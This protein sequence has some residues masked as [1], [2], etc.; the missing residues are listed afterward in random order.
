MKQI[1]KSIIAVLILLAIFSFSIYQNSNTEITNFCKENTTCIINLAKETGD[2]NLC[3]NSLNLE[4]KQI[5]YEKLSF[6]TKNPTLC[7]NTKNQS[8]CYTYLAVNLD[9]IILCQKTENTDKCIFE[10]SV[11]NNNYN[12]CYQTNNSNL[13]IY[14][15]AVQKKDI[16]LCNLSGKYNQSCI[17]KIK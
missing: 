3:E 8:Y 15:Y 13:C 5:C 11:K 7:E 17:D 16:T 1:I 14:S 6:L 4:E 9:N 2:F 10:T 12:Y